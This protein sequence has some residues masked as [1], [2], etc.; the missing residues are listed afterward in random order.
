[1]IMSAPSYCLT[2][3]AISAAFDT[4]G[5]PRLKDVVQRRFGVR[6]NALNWLVDFLM[7]RT[8]VVRTYGYECAIMT[9]KYEVPQVSVLE[10]QRFVAGL[11]QK[12]KLLYHLFRRCVRAATMPTG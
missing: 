2:Y 4:L 6:G 8:Q 3:Q 9:L 1:M 11:L 5:P 12:H 7:G 10:P